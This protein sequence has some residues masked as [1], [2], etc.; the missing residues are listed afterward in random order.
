MWGK[1]NRSDPCSHQMGKKAFIM[2]LALFLCKHTLK[3]S[4]QSLDNSPSLHM[5][6]KETGL[7]TEHIIRYL[8][9]LL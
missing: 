6:P 2:F 3:S 9:Q 7:T 4:C 8:V 5:P 1:E